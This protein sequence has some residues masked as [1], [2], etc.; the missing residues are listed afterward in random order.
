MH[1][2]RFWN[3]RSLETNHL[4]KQFYLQTS[5]LYFIISSMLQDLIRFIAYGLIHSYC[6][7]KGD[8]QKLY[9]I[10]DFNYVFSSVMSPI[11]LY[12][13]WRH[14]IRLKLLREYRAISPY[15]LTQR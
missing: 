2:G 1:E 8:H 9:F 13:K 5:S 7:I 10:K 6:P 4:K 15:I 14:N 12:F 11:M 3:N